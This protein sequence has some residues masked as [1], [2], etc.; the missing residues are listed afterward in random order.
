VADIAILPGGHDKPIRQYLESKSLHEH[1]DRF[2]PYTARTCRAQ[3]KV[4]GAICHGVLALAFAH[5]PANQSLLAEH[6]L[7]TTT[8]PMWMEGT[9]WVASQAWLKGSYYRTYIERGGWCCGDVSRIFFFLSSPR[10]P[11]VGFLRAKCD[12]MQVVIG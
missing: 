10:R 6:G 1:L 3:P 7:Q 8:L 9:A 12:L 4:L 11:F 5:C 2:L